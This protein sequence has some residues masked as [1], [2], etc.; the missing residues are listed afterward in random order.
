MMWLDRC[1]HLGLEASRR[2]ASVSPHINWQ[3]PRF[4]LVFQMKVRIG[5]CKQDR[6]F[7]DSHDKSDPDRR[8]ID[9]VTPWMSM[10]CCRFCSSSASLA[11]SSVSISVAACRCAA[12]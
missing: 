5:L 8:R 3:T 12:L 4:G 6:G 2:L 1:R 9:R 10:T 7:L 11:V